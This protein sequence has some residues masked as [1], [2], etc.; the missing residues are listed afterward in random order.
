MPTIPS[1][2]AAATVSGSLPALTN[3]EPGGQSTMKRKRKTYTAEE[4]E[5][6]ARE[7]AVKKQRREEAKME[8]EAKQ[9][10]IDLEKQARQQEREAKRKQKEEEDRKRDEKREQKKLEQQRAQEKKEKKDRGQA[11]LNM[12]FKATGPLTPKKTAAASTAEAAEGISPTGTPRKDVPVSSDYNKIFQ[13]FFVKESVTLASSCFQL[14]DVAKEAKT[15]NLDQH[16]RGAANSLPAT[17]PRDSSLAAGYFHVSAS[18]KPRGRFCPSVKKIISILADAEGTEAAPVDLTTGERISPNS[19]NTARA[20]LRRVPMKFISFKEDVRPAYQGTMSS[21]A[22]KQLAKL[23]RRPTSR[24][25][26]D[27]NYDYD[28]EGEWIDDEGE[29]IEDLDDDE[30]DADDDDEM[31]DFLD[32]SEDAGLARPA[33]MSGKE[34]ESTGLCWEN[35]QRLGPKPH[36]YKFRMEIIL[37]EI[38]RRT[39]LYLAKLTGTPS[40]TLE[41]QSG[42]DPFSTEYWTPAKPTRVPRVPRAAKTSKAAGI[43]AA[44]NG[45]KA[46][47][48]RTASGAQIMAPPLASGN[49]F[50]ALGLSST[51]ANANKTMPIPAD[52]EQTVRLTLEQHPKLTKLGLV[53]VVNSDLKVY[54]RNHI[55]DWVD[56]LVERSTG[57]KRMLVLKSVS[58]VASEE[59]PCE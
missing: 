10:I 21:A 59:Q 31:G 52:V 35:R 44:T 14:D 56:V 20:M 57:G 15:Q 36:M 19:L 3:P 49:A 24:A 50:A 41:H 6:M 40:G 17:T 47:A 2:P 4:K 46:D 18:L 1:Q 55:K 13:P 58:E 39:A 16:L 42:I 5:E 30:E 43:T 29:D 27:L 48:A 33:Y 11:R 45:K 53:E 23:G 32:D 34:P 37:S 25:I 54:P 9:A 38:P 8:R 22:P 12:F 51:P 26:L 28:S 7:E